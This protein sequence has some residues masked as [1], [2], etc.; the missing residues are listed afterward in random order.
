MQTAVG[1]ILRCSTLSGPRASSQSGWTDIYHSSCRQPQCWPGIVPSRFSSGS[2]PSNSENMGNDTHVSSRCPSCNTDSHMLISIPAAS[3]WRYW[4]AGR[5]Q[6]RFW[7]AS[8]DLHDNT[9]YPQR[10]RR[11]RGTTRAIRWLVV[12][13]TPAQSRENGSLEMLDQQQVA[14]ARSQL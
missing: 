1:Q 4:P 14:D 3:P 11:A 5:V 9:R 13:L 7:I 12:R 10:G 8:C 6:P 2:P